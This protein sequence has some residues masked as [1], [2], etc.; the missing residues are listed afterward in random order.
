[1]ETTTQD[2]LRKAAAEALAAKDDA[3]VLEIIGLL[4]GCSVAL[5][6]HQAQLALPSVSSSSD[7][8]AH[9]Y[10]YWVQ[11]IR[12]NF[13]PFMVENGRGKFTSNE[14]FSWLEN[15]C[16]S[17]FTAGDLKGYPNGGVTWR[18]MASNALTALKQQGVLQSQIHSRVY[19]I[20]TS[21]P[22]PSIHK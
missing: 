20:N 6:P 18:S 3:S 22:I 4:Q 8:P 19:S 11:F 5:P 10:H 14:L 13:I 17:A 7:G 16:A 2:Y 12:E 9:S 1:M 15:C 21:H